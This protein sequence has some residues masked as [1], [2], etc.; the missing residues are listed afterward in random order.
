MVLAAQKLLV[1]LS[2]LASS[3]VWQF[4]HAKLAAAAVVLHTGLFSSSDVVGVQVAQS[5]L[6]RCAAAHLSVTRQRA[7]CHWLAIPFMVKLP[8]SIL[9]CHFGSRKRRTCTRVLPLSGRICAA[10]QQPCFGKSAQRPPACAIHCDMC[11]PTWAHKCTSYVKMTPNKDAKNTR[12]KRSCLQALR[13]T[14][15]EGRQD[16][17]TCTAHGRQHACIECMRHNRE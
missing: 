1:I 9:P 12:K 4:G 17:G 11:T 3:I 8:L 13:S 15:Y 5:G 6:C 7:K 10:I 16:R 14:T 2:T